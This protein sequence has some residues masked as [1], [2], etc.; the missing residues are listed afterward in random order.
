MYI[1][2]HIPRVDELFTK[3]Q[4]G[5]NFSK[6]DMSDAYLQVELDDATK[7]VLVVNTHKGLFRY[8]RLSFGPAPAPAIFQKLVDNLVSGITYVAAYLDDVIV[9]GRTKEEHL[10]HLK[11]VLAA[12][13]EYGMKLRLGKCEFFRQQVTYLGHVISADGMTPSEEHINAIVK[14]PTPENVQQLESFIG[15]T[16]LFRK[17][18]TVVLSHLCPSKPTEQTGP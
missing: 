1:N 13:N 15:K 3:L 11:Q 2:T 8:N 17:V 10:Q 14:I 4:E 12:L 18:L 7:K 5:Q 16:E 6:L 9:T